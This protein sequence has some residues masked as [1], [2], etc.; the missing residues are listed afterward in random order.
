MVFWHPKEFICVAY[1]HGEKG[2]WYLQILQFPEIS[3]AGPQARGRNAER[4]V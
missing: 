1:N 2:N 4:S 3:P